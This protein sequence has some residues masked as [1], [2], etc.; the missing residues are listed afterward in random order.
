MSVEILSYKEVAALIGV[1]RSTLFRAVRA[2]RFPAPLKLRG[3][4]VGF[5]AVEVRDWIAAR[6]RVRYGGEGTE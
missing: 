4:R 5:V 1:H 3:N 6:P 2:G